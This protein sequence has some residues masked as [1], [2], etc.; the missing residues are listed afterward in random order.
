MYKLKLRDDFNPLTNSLVENDEK[1]LSQ[2]TTN[3]N[4]GNENIL[5]A[6]EQPGGVIPT[7]D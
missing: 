4:E 5:V 1:L 3:Q 6:R 2:R 7:S